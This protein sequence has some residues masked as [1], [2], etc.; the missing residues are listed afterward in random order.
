MTLNNWTILCDIKHFSKIFMV[1]IF[2][3]H[4][5]NPFALIIK[6]YTPLQMVHDLYSLHIIWMDEYIIVFLY[7]H[8]KP[9]NNNFL[10]I[11]EFCMWVKY[12]NVVLYRLPVFVFYYLTVHIKKNSKVIGPNL[13]SIQFWYTQWLKSPLDILFK[14][15]FFLLNASVWCL[16]VCLMVFNTTFNNI[17]VIS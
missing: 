8:F 10:F 17:S 11:F 6:Y 16:F 4:I 13:P 7:A 9:F 15:L 5:P 1:L 14:N 2:Y 3:M 12:D